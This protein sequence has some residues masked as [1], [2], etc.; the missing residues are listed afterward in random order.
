MLRKKAAEELKK[1]QERKALERRRVIDERCGKAKSLDGLGEGNYLIMSLA[2]FYL[3]R[4][5]D[6]LYQ[7]GLHSLLVPNFQVKI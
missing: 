1:E 7:S 6:I 4:Q 5:L 2:N 3:R